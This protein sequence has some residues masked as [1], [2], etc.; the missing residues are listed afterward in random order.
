MA[1]HYTDDGTHR[2]TWVGLEEGSFLAL[3]RATDGARREDGALGLGCLAIAIRASERESWRRRLE[4]SGY[5][6]VR[7]SSF[8]L[9]VRDPDGTIVGLCHHPARGS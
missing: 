8:T 1:R 5:P 7:E 9:Y 6:V 4:A 2:A 3:E